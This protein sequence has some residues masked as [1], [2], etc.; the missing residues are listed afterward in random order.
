MGRRERPIPENPP[1]YEMARNGSELGRPETV[2]FSV[3]LA[4]RD[5]IG[6]NQP[7]FALEIG[8]SWDVFD[9]TF[10]GVHC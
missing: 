7:G 6:V 9:A 2:P 10:I 4:I 5:W 1:S 3:E 8:E